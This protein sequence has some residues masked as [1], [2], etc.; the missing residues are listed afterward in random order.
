MRCGRDPGVTSPG[1]VRNANA[2][3]DPAP[4]CNQAV[5]ERG[6]VAIET[7][8]EIARPQRQVFDYVTTPARWE[9]WHPATAGV[10]DVPDRPLSTGETAIEIIA[11]AGR[12][13]E[14]T[15]IVRVCAPPRCWEISTDTPQGAAHIV[16]R[17]API[18][19]G[20]RFVRTLAFRSKHWPWRLLDSTLTRW[21]LKRQSARALRNLKDL[22]ERNGAPHAALDSDH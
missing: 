11:M 22:L 9:T 3:N 5:D 6:Y 19:R 13:V 12:R 7:A 2:V 18:E 8:I 10:R 20:C 4:S 1:P 16:Y 21:L 17:V 14:A 15:W